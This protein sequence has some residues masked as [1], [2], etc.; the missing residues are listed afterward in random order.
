MFEIKSYDI[1]SKLN[2]N[3]NKNKLKV[4]ILIKNKLLNSLTLKFCL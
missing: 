2:I 3:T 1:C 4:K